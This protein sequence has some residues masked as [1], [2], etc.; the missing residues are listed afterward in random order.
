MCLMVNQ[1]V[2]QNVQGYSRDVTQTKVVTRVQLCVF[3]CMCACV[4][5]IQVFYDSFYSK[6]FQ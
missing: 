6:S 3:V 4:A 5:H 1:L 2:P